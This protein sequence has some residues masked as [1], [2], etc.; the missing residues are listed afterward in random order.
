MAIRARTVVLLS[1]AITLGLLALGV[2]G[3]AVYVGSDHGREFLRARVEGVLAG[4]VDGTVH[5]GAIRGSLW[6]D[7]TLDSLEIRDADDSVVVAVG[8]IRAAYDLADLIDRRIALRVLEIERPFVHLRRDSTGDWTYTRLLRSSTGPSTPR[9]GRGFGDV[10]L[11]DSVAI[12]GGAFR[13]TEPWAPDTA[14]RGAAREAAI[15][16]ELARTDHDTR[17]VGDG[18]VRARHWTGLGA[19]LP[20]I[21]VAHPDTAGI[22]ITIGRLDVDESDPP[23]LIRDVRGEVAIVKDSVRLALREFHLPGTVGRASG[24]ITLADGLGVDVRIDADSVS[25]ADLNWVYPNLPL[26]GGGRMTLLIVKPR[27]SERYAYTLRDMDVRSMRSRLQ[28][29]MTFGVTTVLA[30]ISDLDLQLSPLDF[31]LIERFSGE[32]LPLPW[33]GTLTGR[34]R[35]AGGPLDA[36]RIDDVQLAFADGNVRGVVNRFRGSGVLD[37]TEPAQTAFQDFRLNLERFDLRTLQAVNPDFPPVRG[38]LAGTLRLDSAWTDVRFRDLAMRWTDDTLPSSRFTG[39]GRVTQLDDDLLY[40]LALSLDSLS[41]DALTNS[42]PDLGARGMIAG[43]F[44]ARGTTSDLALDGAWSGPAGE[45]R[46]TLRL[47][48]AEP[49]YGVSGHVDLVGVDPAG[50]LSAAAAASGEVTAGIDVALSGDSL[51]DLDGGLKVVLDRS[52]VG[53]LRLYAGRSDFLF[54]DGRMSV[55]TITLETSAFSLRGAGGLGLREGVTDSVRFAVVIDSLGGVR[56]LSTLLGLTESVPTDSL[57]GRLAGRGVLSGTVDELGLVLQVSG[58]DLVA[59]TSTTRALSLTASLRD[60]MGDVG[61]RVAVQAD[62]AQLGGVTLSRVVAAGTLIDGDAAA[63]EL[64]V[65]SANGPALR[66]VAAAQWDS[67]GTQV[68]V[69]TLTLTL[70]DSRWR[71]AAP[72]QIVSSADGVRLDS[73]TLLTSSGGRLALRGD[74]PEVGPIRG[75]FDAVAVPIADLSLLA[76]RDE[77]AAGAVGLRV[78]LAGTRDL[79]TVQFRGEVR[80]ARFGDARLDEVRLGGRYADRL[81]A[82]TMELRVREQQVARVEASLPV[83]LALRTVPDRF[84]DA[85]ITGQLIADSTELTVLEAFTTAVR[86]AAGRFD[87]RIAL[88]G[89]WDRPRIDGRVAVIDGAFG[90]P[91]LGSV[92]WRN[93]QGNIDF[94]GDTVHLRTLTANSGGRGANT[95]RVFGW[96]NLAD[97]KD[98][99]FDVRVITQQFRAIDKANVATLDL[100]AQLRLAGKESGSDLTGSVTIDAGNVYVPDVYRKNVISLDD[101]EFFRI[102]DTTVFANRQLLPSAQSALVENLR[103]G[104]VRINAGPDLWLRSSEANVKLGGSLAVT[105]GRSQRASDRGERQ[106][107]L[108]GALTAERGTYRLNLGALVQRTF[109]VEGGTLRFFGDPDNNAALDIAA[110]YTIRQFEQGDARQDV[111]VRVVLSGTLLSPQVRLESPDSVRV[112]GADLI[113]YLVTGQPSFEVGGRASDYTSTAANVLFQSLGSALGSRLTGGALDVFEVQTASVGG[114]NTAGGRNLGGSLLSGTRLSGAGQLTDNLFLR[115]DAGLCQVGQLVGEGGGNFDPVA[116]ADAVGIKLD[117]R[118]TDNLGVS[119]GMEPSTS[120]LLCASGASA[121]G[122]APTPRQWGVDFFRAWRF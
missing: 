2:G 105:A 78:E 68:R 76:Q 34:V 104:N 109:E 92:R 59:G 73:L 3:L 11:L 58:R 60:V 55:D 113:S 49:T 15:T 61:G 75:L 99:E 51:A 13:W 98:L 108:D 46:A 54:A 30:D 84:V 53:D 41:L 83:D 37:I 119:G 36:F 80:D 18:F 111:R 79:P 52:R 56:T 70:P 1:A 23:L 21:L 87:A 90:L 74:L 26:E 91:R 5:L 62:T 102:V 72:A 14:L 114:L 106:L 43:N 63:L 16:E 112:S 20:H 19:E 71:L 122:F 9:T 6:S 77:A 101:P 121:R 47:D 65:L 44:T 117:W 10:V 69:D 100:S 96:V 67:A 32:P 64:D 118:F 22:R 40:D 66:G 25:L 93:V 35:G 110:L 42:Y 50:W 116:L 12:R 82:G 4:R 48:V 28:G 94:A 95:G 8:P 81:L 27:D 33:A 115:I 103:V 88:T 38:W 17:R 97:P 45:V 31:V 107:A 24:V 86:G 85:P 57:S 7:F 89:T 120:A 39:Q 29:T